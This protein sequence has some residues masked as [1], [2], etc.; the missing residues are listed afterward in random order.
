MDGG[1]GAPPFDPCECIF[2][3]EGAMRRLISLLRGSQSYCTEEQCFTDAPNL[4][5]SN[6]GGN[7]MMFVMVAWVIAAVL[8]YLLR[9]AS[10]RGG[11]EKPNPNNGNREEQPPAPTA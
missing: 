4:Q 5:A 6:D 11:S 3:H 10:M 1:G 9:P 2:S 8:L 7:M